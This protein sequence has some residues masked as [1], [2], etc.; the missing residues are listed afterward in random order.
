MIQSRLECLSQVISHFFKICFK[1][2]EVIKQ[3]G[4]YNTVCL[5][6]ALK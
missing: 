2:Y 3:Y 6:A 1:T 4:Y 5:K